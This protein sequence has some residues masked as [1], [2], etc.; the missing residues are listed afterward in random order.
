MKCLRC[1]TELKDS[2]VFCPECNKVTSVPL[3]SSPFMSKKI[4]LPKRTPAQ[5]IKKQE[6][7]KS[8]K[9]EASAGRWILLSLFL[10][11]LCGALILQGAYIYEEN[12]RI[13]AELARLQSAE[14][15]CVRL[16]D[17]LRKA[18]E[19]VRTLEEELT[20]LGSGSYLEVRAELK[21]AK[22]TVDR[23]NNDLA[24]WEEAYTDLES[25]TEIL[26]E[27]ADFFVSHIVFVQD[28]K[29]NHFHSYDCDKFSRNGYLAYNKEQALSLGYE[30]CPICQ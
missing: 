2:N 28:D 21:E 3:P 7:K 12:D 15:E 16:T 23:L 19:E 11:L 1:G 22:E 30:P 14:D 6:I 9:K 13:T 27:K 26:R 24:R 25:R 18:E 4:E 5:S 29:T 20:N 10:L 8:T 17:K